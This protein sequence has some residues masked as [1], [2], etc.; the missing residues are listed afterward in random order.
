MQRILDT[1]L[2]FFHFN[3]CGGAYF[4]NCHATRQLSQAFLQFLA[5]V[6]RRCFFSLTTQLLDARFY[7][8]RRAGAVNDGSV[9]FV[10][11]NSLGFTQVVE[12]DTF[13]PDAGLFHNGFSACEYGDVLQHRF[14]PI[15][16]TRSLYSTDVQSAA[17]F[18][19]NQ[20]AQ[21][22]PFHILGDNQERFP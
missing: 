7:V 8:L 1:S 14:A 19:H 13:Q 11:C 17:Q 4:D 20:R 15:T 3:L 10:H 18:V 6:I 22:F 9:V 21:G 16:E 12:C 5:I 2:L